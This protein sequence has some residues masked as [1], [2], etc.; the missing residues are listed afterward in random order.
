MVIQISL[1]TTAKLPKGARYEMLDEV[2]GRT[3]A[4]G[5]SDGE[6]TLLSLADEAK[7]VMQQWQIDSCLFAVSGL[8][9]CVLSRD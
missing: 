6:D 9:V 5:I 8:T 7:H 3:L 1:V 2:S 4:H